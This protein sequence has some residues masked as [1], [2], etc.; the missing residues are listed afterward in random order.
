MNLQV[1]YSCGIYNTCYY[2]FQSVTYVVFAHYVRLPAQIVTSA[3]AL[4]GFADSTQP[5]SRASSKETEVEVEG[6]KNL[7]TAPIP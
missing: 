1:F 2:C 4:S 3:W 5:R 6:T 7:T